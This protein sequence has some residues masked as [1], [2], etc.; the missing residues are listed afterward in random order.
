MSSWSRPPTKI[1]KKPGYSQ[2]TPLGNFTSKTKPVT[3]VSA[4]YEV[5]SRADQATYKERM[6]LFLENIP[7]YLIFFCEEPLVE[8]INTCRKN[9]LDRTIVIPL[10]R[11]EWVANIKYGEDIWLSQPEKDNEKDLHSIDL[12]K[13]WYEKKEFVLTAIELNPYDHDDFM[14]MDAGII[15]EEAVVPLIKNNF[16]EAKRIPTDRMLLLHVKPFDINDEVKTN[17]VT[18]QFKQKDR[19][20]A[21][22]IA[23]HKDTWLKWSEV[24]DETMN[25]YIAANMFIGKE[26]S[27]MSTMVL[28]NKSLVSLIT[29]PNNFGRKWFYSLIY[30][31]VSDKRLNVINSFAA[32]TIESFQSIAAIHS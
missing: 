7:C 24:Y 21:G 20:A 29:P 22:I 30:L 1:V 10:N 17:N 3:V 2:K 16:P 13:L 12:Y 15:R 27:I 25:R 6:R 19:I 31:G 5:P 28:E 14:W 23:G 18:G 32:D 4:Y 9:F 8:F 11:T 26:Q